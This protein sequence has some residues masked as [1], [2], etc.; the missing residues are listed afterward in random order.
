M[1]NEDRTIWTV[2]NGEIYN[3]RQLRRILEG[4][5]H[6]FSGRS[7]TEVLP[8]LYE[9]EESDF[10]SRLRGMFAFAIYDTRKSKLLLA[11][12]RFGIKPLF[13]ALG[14]DWL[15]FA[16]ELRALLALPHI[17]TR[18]DSQAIYDFTA[19]SYIPAPETFYKGIRA[20]EPGNVLE[21]QLGADGI[22]YRIRQYHVWSLGPAREMTLHRAVDRAEELITSAVEAQLESDVPLGALLSGG[23]D[24]SLTSLAAQKALSGQLRTFNVQFPDKQYDESW[25]ATIVAKQIGSRHEML[26]MS[27]G[28]GNWEQ[29]TDLLLHVG[30][31]FADTS[32]FAVNA[33]SR[34]M[35]GRVTVAISGDGGDEAFCG[36]DAYW[37]LARI[38]RWQ[39]LP[40]LVGAASAAALAAL[41]RFGISTRRLSYRIRDLVNADDTAVVQS[42]FS[43]MTEREH[44]DLWGDTGLLPVRRLF[45]KTWNHDSDPGRSRID[46]LLAHATEVNVRL[47]LPNDF[48]FKVDMASMKESLEIRV[49]MLDE[50]LFGFGLSLPPQI[51]IDGRTG[52]RILRE[53]AARHLPPEVAHKPK[54]GF[55]V[56]LET[57]FAA[58]LKA[59]LRDVLMGPGSVLSDFLRPEVYRLW[60]DSLCASR[61]TLTLSRQELFARAIM[62]LSLQ[63]TLC[64]NN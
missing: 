39:G 44:Q 8:H 25:A 36:Y 57:W 26:P 63:L 54:W 41:S 35:R 20:L 33:I 42:L 52:K 40:S 9:E 56:P 6:S 17:D 32:L 34:L 43:F 64:R 14:K 12:D 55:A 30:Q 53:V 50:E 31:P 7:D 11:R 37:R 60:V 46:R 21:A 47:T 3:H 45:E 19:L 13:Y 49:P 1:A 2:F 59:N 61:S 15:A 38:A 51:K 5:C 27:G 4:K 16:S 18:P 48:L 28:R 58:D 22:S 24:S 23:I 10:V 29:V 62:L